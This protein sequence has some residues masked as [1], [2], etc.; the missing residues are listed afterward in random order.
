MLFFG[1]GGDVWPNSC[2]SSEHGRALYPPRDV[3][4]GIPGSQRDE[5]EDRRASPCFVSTVVS[6]EPAL[7]SLL[8]ASDDSLAQDLPV[9]TR[10]DLAE[11]MDITNRL[12]QI[13]VKGAVK[14]GGSGEDG[15]RKT[16]PNEMY[17]GFA[18]MGEL[19]SPG[20]PR[21]AEEIQNRKRAL[22]R[23]RVKSLELEWVLL[24]L[25]WIM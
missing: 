8:L 22:V 1:G 7:A 14:A 15:F 19:G 24:T 6:L 16:R 20:R 3:K 5:A 23:L 25:V 10:E 17:R 2:G 12:H 21:K 4:R 9:V 11:L 13:K 18:A